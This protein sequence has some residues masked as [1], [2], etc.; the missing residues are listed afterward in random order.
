MSS[1]GQNTPYRPRRAML[2]VPAHVERHIEKARNLPC[3]SIIFDLQE[4]VPSSFKVQARDTLAAALKRNADFGHAERVL[5][6]NPLN[7]RWGIDDLALAASLPVDA[8]LVPRIESAQQVLDTLAAL[9]ARGGAH[10]N[11]MCNIESP[12]GVLRA[13]AI[14]G[15]SP[16]VS[17]LVM[18]TTDLANELKINPTPERTGLITSLSLV[19]LAA[20]AH[21]KGVVDGPHFNLKDVQACEFACRQA[22][23]LGFDGKAIIHP[24]QLAYTNDAFTPKRAD[25]E[26]AQR[27]I[28]ALDEAAQQGM[29]TA[30]VDDR[31]IEPA[32]EEW[33]RRVIAVFDA[34]NSLGQTELLGQ[35]R[36][37]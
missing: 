17:C 19:I 34:V 9:D 3:D 18:G 12:F 11:L 20:R 5:R 35:S 7:S 14:A 33:A 2:Y 15:A 37:R 24:V 10:L 21:R 32:M 26:R 27:V 28:A 8:L 25:V 23:D 13:E 31:L 29:S 6:I 36:R 4:S 1:T 16:R 22:R 30:V